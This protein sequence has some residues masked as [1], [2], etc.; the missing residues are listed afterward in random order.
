MTTER[1]EKLRQALD[2]LKWALG[3]GGVVLIVVASIP[4]LQAQAAPWISIAAQIVG[5]ILTAWSAWDQYNASKDS[6]ILSSAS[7]VPGVT[8]HDNKI[9]VNSDEASLSA[10]T[11]AQSNKV[12]FNQIVEEKK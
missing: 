3:P 9:I 10:V 4:S 2:F 7:Q 5:G 12:E 6:S 8:F 11:A 1:V